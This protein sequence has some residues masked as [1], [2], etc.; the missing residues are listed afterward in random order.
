MFSTIT[1]ESSTSKP[2]AMTSPNTQL[3]GVYPC[4]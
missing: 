1:I 4:N 2:N 3:I